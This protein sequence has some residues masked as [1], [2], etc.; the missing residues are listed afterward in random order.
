MPGASAADW[1]RYAEEDLDIADLVLETARP[2]R[3]AC[4]HAEQAAEKALK[5]VLVHE[6]IR[7]AKTHKL[8]ELGDLLPPDSITAAANADLAKLSEWA[9]EIRYPDA[10]VDASQEDALKAVEDARLLFEAS[11]Q[12]LES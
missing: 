1:L 6:G 8:E 2:P 4:F 9:D 7:Y 3:L 10:L 11:R 5:A 12:D